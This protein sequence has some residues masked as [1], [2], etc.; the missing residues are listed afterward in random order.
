MKELFSALS[1][2][3]SEVK[4]PDKSSKGVHDASYAQIDVV[5][6]VAR[7]LLG[8][9]GLS[10]SHFPISAY[11]DGKYHIGLKSYL[12]HNSGDSIVNEFLI[13][14]VNI[15]PQRIGAVFTYLKRQSVT[16]ILGITPSDED[17]DADSISP[18]AIA[19]AKAVT[20]SV[21]VDIASDAQINLIRKLGGT[22]EKGMSKKDASQMIESLQKRTETKPKETKINNDDIPW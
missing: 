4:N 8:K 10:V 18:G 7:P 6:D 22:P 5:W 14:L 9:Y 16:A 2:F 13:P 17:D 11:I 20:K 1:K 3:Q 15:H 19:K 21:V 12:N